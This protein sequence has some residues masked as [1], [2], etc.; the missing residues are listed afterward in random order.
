MQLSD[1]AHMLI[2]GEYALGLLP[3]TVS[4]RW[5]RLMAAQPALAELTA[6]WQ[7]QLAPMANRLPQHAVPAALWQSIE[8]ELFGSPQPAAKPAISAP[9]RSA[10]PTRRR[11]W[12]M[13]AALAAGLS[14]WLALPNTQPLIIPDAPVSSTQLIATLSSEQQAVQW[15]VST[16]DGQSLELRASAPWSQPAERSLQLWAL[17]AS[18]TPHSLGV[19]NLQDDRAI[20]TLSLAEREWLRTATLLAISDE[21]AGGSPTPLPTGPVIFTGKPAQG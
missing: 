1:H 11:T 17:D 5:E 7:Q 8:A 19:L 16:V 13:A 12:L 20:L 18:G 10:T 21:P 2:G 3:P 4:K 9:A 14:L 6:Q 15:Q